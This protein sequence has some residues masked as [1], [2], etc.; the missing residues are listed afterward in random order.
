MSVVL[1]FEIKSAK[2]DKTVNFLKGHFSVMGDTMDMIFK[3]FSETYVTYMFSRSSKSY[4]N[5]N[6]KSCLKLNDP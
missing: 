3:M 4:D 6:V 5:L 2:R 1:N